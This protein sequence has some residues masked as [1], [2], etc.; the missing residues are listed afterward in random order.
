[1]LLSN[2]VARSILRM[3]V[4]RKRRASAAELLIIARPCAIASGR[5]GS[6]STAPIAFQQLAVSP[7]LIGPRGL[8]THLQP[9]LFPPGSIAGS[10]PTADP[11]SCA[12]LSSR[13][14]GQPGSLRMDQVRRLA[15]TKQSWHPFPTL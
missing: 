3:S 1:M 15:S 4:L 14:E 12:P 13:S 6:K 8:N 9:V 10:A 11:R 2:V 5:A 7:V